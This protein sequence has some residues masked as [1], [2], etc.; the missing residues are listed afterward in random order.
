M[1]ILVNNGGSHKAN[2][3][4]RQSPHAQVR[5]GIRL[6]N[7]RALTGGE[8]YLTKVGNK[9][10]VSLKEAAVRHGTNAV[11]LRA[12]IIVLKANDQNWIGRLLHGDTILAA[13][14]LLEPQVKAIEAL[15]DANSANLQAIYTATGFTNELTK[16]LAKSSSAER[17]SAA[18]DFGH[19]DIIWDQMVVPT[20]SVNAAE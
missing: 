18:R 12:A 13:A 1:R 7:L 19:P 3:K 5:D 4:P 6:A 14:K 2:G 17:T 15:K 20:I 11:Y 10:R 9:E 16:L 8:W